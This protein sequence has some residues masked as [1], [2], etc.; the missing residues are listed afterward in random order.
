M[1]CHSCG[2]QVGDDLQFCSNCGQPLAPG[3]TP[4]IVPP[5]PPMPWT[6]AV[7]IRATPGR[8]IGEGWQ[9]VKSDM[10]NLALMAFL[11]GILGATIVTQGP[12]IVGF[13]IVFIKKMHNRPT[14]LGD[15]F[16]GFN[17]FVPALVASLIISAFTALGVVLCIVGSLVIGSALKFTYLFIVDKRMDFWPAIQSSHAVVKNDYFGFTMFLLLIGLVNMLGFLCCIVGVF[18]TMPIGIAAITVAYREI[19]GFDPRTVDAL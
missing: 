2:T 8:W 10:F 13:H 12:M 15:L 9:M 17:Y 1:F 19:V 4:V 3:A 5:P 16:K 18:V 14:E 7:G 11:T 6:P